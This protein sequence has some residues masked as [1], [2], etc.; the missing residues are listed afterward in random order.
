VP[1]I[2]APKLTALYSAALSAHGIGALPLDATVLTI[3]GLHALASPDIDAERQR[4]TT[5]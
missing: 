3:A 2:G 4:V 5:H 1:I